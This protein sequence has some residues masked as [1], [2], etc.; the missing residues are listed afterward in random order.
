[1]FKLAT[2]LKNDFLRNP[3]ILKD[4]ISS[5]DNE[6][7]KAD[8]K[9]S[10]AEIANIVQNA[11]S[12]FTLFVVGKTKATEVVLEEFDKDEFDKKDGY[13]TYK[14]IDCFLKEIYGLT[15]S[16]IQNKTAREACKIL[17]NTPRNK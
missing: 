14:E 7:G 4:V 9:F 1:M 15:F 10:K 2:F 3:N 5:Y 17:D 12:V 11:A 8:G 16:D 6:G 13:V